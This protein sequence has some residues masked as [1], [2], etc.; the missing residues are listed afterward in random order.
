MHAVPSLEHLSV[1]L[2]RGESKKQVWLVSWSCRQCS[3][4]GAAKSSGMQAAWQL[5]CSKCQRSDLVSDRGSLKLPPSA[6][7][8][9]HPSCVT[10]SALVLLQQ[11]SNMLPNLQR[12]H[13]MESPVSIDYIGTFCAALIGFCASLVELRIHTWEHHD[14]SWRNQERYPVEA[15]VQVLHTDARMHQLRTLSIRDWPVLVS[16]DCG[17]GSMLRE[18]PRLAQVTVG[19]YPCVAPICREGRCVHFDRFLPFK[20]HV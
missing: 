6:P 8:T 9:D 14:Q 18:L 12:L 2:P 13:L 10:Q 19:G 3:H 4:Y 7:P 1:R 16:N 17:G 5:C 20:K 11:A 15:R